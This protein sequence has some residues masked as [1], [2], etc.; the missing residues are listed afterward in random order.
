MKTKPRIPL[1]QN[2][3][4]RQTKTRASLIRITPRQKHRGNFE[5]WRMPTG[6]V[7]ISLA[8]A[9]QSG[10]PAPTLKFRLVSLKFRIGSG[11][12]FENS[13]TATKS[14][15]SSRN[16]T[17]KLAARAGLRKQRHSARKNKTALPTTTGRLKKIC[18]TRAVY[19]E[20]DFDRNSEATRS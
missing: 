3:P 13:T 1:L 9:K 6:R 5:E 17:G 20:K 10:S 19:R 16:K 15:K 8:K 18:G 7:P 2:R 12:Y 14:L 11:L 4:Q